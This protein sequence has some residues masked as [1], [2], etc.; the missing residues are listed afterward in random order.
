MS[1]STRIRRAAVAV[2]LAV[3]AAGAGVVVPATA[4][5]AS[6]FA[7]TTGS[8]GVTIRDCY[9]PTNQSPSTSCTYVAFVPAYTPVRI[10]CQ[11]SGQNIGGDPVWD[12]I[13][14][15]G[16]SGRPEGFASDYYINTGYANWIPGVSGC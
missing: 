1:T 16:G 6:W 8:S 2:G 11:R 10:V 13:V 4:A 7:A 15:E 3:A 14:W 5:Q 9:H 12:Y